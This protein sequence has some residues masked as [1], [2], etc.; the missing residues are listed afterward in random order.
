[1][2]RENSPPPTP[3]MVSSVHVPAPLPVVLLGFK[4]FS[5]KEP[6]NIFLILL[7]IATYV[8]QF[9]YSE[10]F[11]CLKAEYLDVNVGLPMSLA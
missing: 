8:F 9:L 10:Y 5:S 11:V 2:D 4:V 1:M 7:H 6:E 3:P